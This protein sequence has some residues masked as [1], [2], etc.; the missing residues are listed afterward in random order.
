MH[1]NRHVPSCSRHNA[2]GTTASGPRLGRF[3]CLR[4]PLTRVPFSMPSHTLVDLR[5]LRYAT[6]K[7]RG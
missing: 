5:A 1:T 7:L 4:E 6:M 3:A 2:P